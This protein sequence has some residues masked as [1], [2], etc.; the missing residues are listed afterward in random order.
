MITFPKGHVPWNKGK[1]LSAE[2]RK[3][4]SKATK[5]WYKT[6]DSMLKGREM[7]EELVENK[8]GRSEFYQSYEVR[9]GNIA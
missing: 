7:L 8:T 6:H 5:S 2:H 1:K 4:I 3:H 9:E